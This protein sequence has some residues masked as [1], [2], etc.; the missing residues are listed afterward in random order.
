MT[1]I[2]GS[3]L[4]DGNI[5]VFFYP[6]NVIVSDSYKERL[7]FN[8]STS[9]LSLHSVQVND[10]GLYVLQGMNPAVKAE[11]NLTVQGEFPN[12]HNHRHFTNNFYMIYLEN[13]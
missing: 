9:Q 12:T 7:S 13:V 3:W 2:S 5:L 6:D 8:S 11:L 10:S 1:I 4:L